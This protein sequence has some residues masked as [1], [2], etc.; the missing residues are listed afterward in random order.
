MNQMQMTT[1]VQ[2]R[3]QAALESVVSRL[4]EDYYVLAAVLYGSLARGEAWER[5]D[6]DLVVV[7]KDGQER[8]I[9]QWELV[10]NDIHVS[11]Y[12]VTRNRLKRELEGSLQGSIWHSIRSQ[13]KVLFSKDELIETWLK[14]SKRVG[15]HDQEFQLLQSVSPVPYYIDKAEKWLYVKQDVNYCLMWLLFAVNALAR[16]EVVLNGEAPGRE[17]LD[18]AMKFNP[19]FF[20]SNYIDLINGPK[21]KERLG[22]VLEQIDQYLLERSRLVF[23]AV[24]DYLAEVQGP[25]GLSDLETHFK[26]KVP[27]A[28]LS[29]V[30]DWMARKNIIHKLSSPVRLT[31][32]SQVTL[33]EPAYYYDVEDVADWE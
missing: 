3:Y 12:V 20:G 23:K 21:T 1:Q 18:Q 16:V 6:I 31:R 30:Y 19:D 32:K 2:E 24:L 26:K 22:V 17:A 27:D 7:L 25:C 33:D 15:A 8:E 28:M 11:A 10:E 14:E 4:Q 5:S 9:R 29:G 13:F